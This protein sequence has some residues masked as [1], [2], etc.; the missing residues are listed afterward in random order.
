MTRIEIIP[1][2]PKRIIKGKLT[3]EPELDPRWEWHRNQALGMPD[4]YVKIRCNHLEL[5]PVTSVTGEHV[6]QLCR[7][8]DTQL[9][10][11]DAR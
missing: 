4:R 6:A 10:P 8:C 3:M 7:T 9:P 11:G 2:N 5:E 1:L